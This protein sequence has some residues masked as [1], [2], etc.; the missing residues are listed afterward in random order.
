MR[1]ASNCGLIWALFCS[2]QAVHAQP[3]DLAVCLGGGLPCTEEAL[4]RRYMSCSKTF[5]VY[6]G[7]V[8]WGPLLCVGPITV[9][10]EAFNLPTTRYPLYVEIVPVATPPCPPLSPG[11]LI[12]ST[13]G[14]GSCPAWQ[15]SGPIDI[16]R[17]IPLGSLYQLQL[18]F[19]QSKRSVYDVVAAGWTWHESTSERIGFAAKCSFQSRGV[20]SA[21]SAAGWVATRCRTSTK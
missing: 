13:L 15:T 19:F 3:A 14:G 11:F 1:V 21:T 18:V 2:A 20:S 8:G 10:V 17:I 4:A 7:R 5:Y 12:A 6:S 16:T 9:E